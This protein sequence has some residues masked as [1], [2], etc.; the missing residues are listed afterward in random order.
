VGGVVFREEGIHN[1]GGSSLGEKRGANWA[2]RGGKCMSKNI[3]S[4]AEFEM[5]QHIV[6]VGYYFSLNAVHFHGI[7]EF[8][9]KNYLKHHMVVI[10][11]S[12]ISNYHLIFSAGY[13]YFFTF[14][15]GNFFSFFFSNLLIGFFVILR[16]RW[17]FVFRYLVV[18][19]FLA[20]HFAHTFSLFRK[21]NF[22]VLFS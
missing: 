5:T 14:F 20:K 11:V 1:L 21:K 13:F 10:Y 6:V 19:I 3:P 18:H 22:D 15:K 7:F 12:V 4:I 16:E 17:I 2:G 9:G 8:I